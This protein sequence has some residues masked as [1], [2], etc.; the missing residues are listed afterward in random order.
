[1]L[2]NKMAVAGV[3]QVYCLC[4]QRFCSFVRPHNPS[5]FSRGGDM[6]STG[7]QERWWRAED[8]GGL[9]KNRNTNKREQ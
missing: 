6:V 2:P 9:V 5:G 1:M 4:L 8:S 7:L 3:S